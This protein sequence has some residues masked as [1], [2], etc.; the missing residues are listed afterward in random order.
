MFN[1]RSTNFGPQRIRYEPINEPQRMSKEGNFGVENRHEC[2]K[3]LV[4]KLGRENWSEI[5]GQLKYL[6]MC[7]IL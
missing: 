5:G 6:D 3:K 1:G 4:L 2:I 7:P